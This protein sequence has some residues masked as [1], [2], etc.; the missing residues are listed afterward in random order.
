MHRV[1]M[2]SPERDEVDTGGLC[3]PAAILQANTKQAFHSKAMS[4]WYATMLALQVSRNETRVR[5]LSPL[6]AAEWRA[7]LGLVKRLGQKGWSGSPGRRQMREGVKDAGS[8][9]TR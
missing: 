4:G 2:S 5:L 7:R 3:F 6:E 1:R 8:E 9:R